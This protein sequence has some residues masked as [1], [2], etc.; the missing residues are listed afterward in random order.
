MWNKDNK[1]EINIKKTRSTR[2]TEAQLFKITP[3]PKTREGNNQKWLP[4]KNL[5][6][7]TVKNVKKKM[8]IWPKQRNV[9]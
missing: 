2:I 3:I 5:G 8:E 9:P 1:K 6:S 7:K 4:H